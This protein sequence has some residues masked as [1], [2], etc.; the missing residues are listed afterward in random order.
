MIS[1]LLAAYN[2]AQYIGEQIKSIQNQTISDFELLVCD[3]CSTDNT[4]DI[5]KEYAKL[6]NR[7]KIF[8]NEENLGFKKNFERLLYLSCGEY[9][10]LSDQDD[11]WT[12]NHL[13]KLI[14]SIGNNDLICG[15]AYL[16]DANGNSIG[17]TLLDCA[18]F[19]FLPKNQD[20]WF[21][22][23]LHG[24]IFQGA[25]CLFRNSLLPYILPIP[26]KVRFHDYWIAIQA[27]LHGGVTYL[28]EPVL[29]YRQHGKNVTENKNFSYIE[30]I[31]RAFFSDATKKKN[32][33][34]IE[35]LLALI[36]TIEDK[37]RK[38]QV[39]VAFKYFKRLNSFFKLPAFFYFCKNYRF[40]YL[41]NNKPL[42]L[43]RIFK[44]FLFGI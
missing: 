39:E 11:I 7:I 42:F 41:S 17:S 40:V 28:N 36:N 43:L 9:I 14:T 24:S 12:D 38:I 21:F 6:D 8:R 20:E 13:E 30:M 22:F 1:I 15:N 10:A 44:K 19:D 26:K 2:G 23:L 3:D 27:C 29:F 18:H 4:F 16:V 5:L 37:S 35:F 31:L 25:A 34:Q 32:I 33:E